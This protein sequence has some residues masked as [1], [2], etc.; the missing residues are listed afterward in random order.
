MTRT[1]LPSPAFARALRRLSK[2]Q[3]RLAAEVRSTL[4]QLA[5]DAWHP[6]LKTHKLTGKMS[7]QY[8]CSVA[9]DLR[10]IFEFLNLDGVE[11][12]LLESVG[13]HDD[14]Y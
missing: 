3:P 9:Y 8:S 1:L 6:R 2:R 10:I 11:A 7:E 14:V 12:I 13:S 4:E 5:E